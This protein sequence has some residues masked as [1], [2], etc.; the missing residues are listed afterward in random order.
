MG[1][2][3]IN[4]ET[5]ITWEIPL[6]YGDLPP[7]NINEWDDNSWMVEHLRQLADKIEKENPRIINIGLRMNCQYKC[8]NLYIELYERR[9]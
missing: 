6:V 3:I 1:L 5:L 9:H 2:A 7:D 8:P 4:S